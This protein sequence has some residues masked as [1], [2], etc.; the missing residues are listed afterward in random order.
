[1]KCIFAIDGVNYLSPTKREAVDFINFWYQECI[2]F[3]SPRPFK[4]AWKLHGVERAPSYGQFERVNFD[5][6]EYK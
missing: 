3:D 5:Q 4:T 1:M 2:T 6:V